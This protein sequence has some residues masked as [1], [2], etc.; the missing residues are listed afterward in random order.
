MTC[1]SFFWLGGGGGGGGNVESS[2]FV[3]N[4][5]RFNF[6][7]FKKIVPFFTS[8]FRYHQKA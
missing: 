6:S 5:N 1:S 3:L 7:P 4:V 2:S 8:I